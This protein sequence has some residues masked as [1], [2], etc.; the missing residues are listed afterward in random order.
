[1][2]DDGAAIMMLTDDSRPPAP[3]AG[4]RR[5]L[6]RPALFLSF[7]A[8]PAIAMAGDPDT[9]EGNGLDEDV[10][11]WGGQ[12]TEPCGWP[13]VVRVTGPSSL[14][15]GTLIHPDVV[16]YAAHCGT[17]DRVVRFGDSSNST[18]TRA[19]SYCRAS[20]Q[21][22]GWQDYDWAYCVLEEPVFEVPITPVGYGCEVNQYLYNG[23]TVAV[24]G[25]GNDEGDSGSGRKRWAFTSLSNLESH[26]FDVGGGGQ[27]TICSGDS[28]GPAYIQYD[29]GTWHAYGIASTKNSG[30]CDQARGTHSNAVNAVAWIEQ[31]SGIDVTVCHDL[32]GA[33]NPGPY[34]GDIFN[35]Q[36]ALGY[37]SWNLWCPDAPSLEW[38]ATCGS[39][40][41]ELNYEANPPA[42]QF[43][44]PTNGQ[45]FEDSPAE[46]DITVL[47]ED[48]SDLGVDVTLALD[49]EPLQQVISESPAVWDGAS[50][51]AGTYTLT[52]TGVDFW[53]NQTVDE[54]TF[55][56]EG[57]SG[58]DG[59]T[60]SGEETTSDDDG[61]DD[62]VGEDT[63][64][65]GTEDGFNPGA[66]GGL[67]TQ[68]CACST[69]DSSDGLG[70]GGGALWFGL[71]GIGLLGL[72]RR[73]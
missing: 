10:E 47:A 23:Q 11:V 8:F 69:G 68:G 56:V 48:D 4:L 28:G 18:K 67:T 31:D 55:T 2:T 39:T 49:G 36:P 52:A 58:D 71:A 40:F 51:P 15:S 33:W 38:S 70:F 46:F 60:T 9:I 19:T 29:D 72:R 61:G 42:V 17:Q 45:V 54:V 6:T 13:S 44:V 24:V 25:F 22:N 7:L 27:P 73:R 12:E 20:P 57:A 16:M 63:G 14:C 59:E 35:G 41:E 5:A 32:N 37:G 34:C 1:M 21:Y 53:G 3:Y 66:D 30:T 50:F 43:Q 62:E 65:L 64:D 26:R